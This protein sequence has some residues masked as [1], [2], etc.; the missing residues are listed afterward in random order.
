MSQTKTRPPVIVLDASE[1]AQQVMIKPDTDDRFI[2]TVDAAIRACQAGDQSYRFG[3]QFTDLIGHLT[4]WIKER[5]EAIKTA[6]VTVRTSD[7]LFY[8]MQK[9]VPHDDT[10]VTDLTELDLE[11]ANSEEFD[12]IELNVM[13]VPCVSDGSSDAFL[14]SG[15]V[16]TYHA[17]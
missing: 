2:M 10:L 11:I 5:S 6:A 3:Q 1:N 15:Q 12:L 7:I 14:S 17:Q 8:V 9:D 16:F 4:Q 13:S